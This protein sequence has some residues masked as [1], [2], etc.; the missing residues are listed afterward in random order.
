VLSVSLLCQGGVVALM[1]PGDQGMNWVSFLNY[2]DIEDQRLKRRYPQLDSEKMILARC[3]KLS[4]EMGELSD[5]ILSQLG[6]QRKEKLDNFDHKS[7][8]K[9]FA[10][11]IITAFLLA[12]SADIDILQALED[13]IPELNQRA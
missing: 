11:L 7:L 2:I 4:E 5:N 6:L 8:T 10:D 12:K 3:V 1:K 9:E 13:K